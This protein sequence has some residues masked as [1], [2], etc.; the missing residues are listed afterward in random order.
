MSLT[1]RSRDELGEEFG[2]VRGDIVR[3]EA[4]TNYRSIEQYY[5][6]RKCRVFVSKECGQRDGKLEETQ[7]DCNTLYF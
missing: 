4:P 3:E 1:F 7:E 5:I 2:A 6:P